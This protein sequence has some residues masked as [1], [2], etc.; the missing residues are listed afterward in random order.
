MSKTKK[1]LSLCY[2]FI[3]SNGIEIDID[4]VKGSI[5]DKLNNNQMITASDLGLVDIDFYIAK[6]DRESDYDMVVNKLGEPIDDLI[7]LILSSSVKYSKKIE[8]LLNKR[9]EDDSNIK[10]LMIG[11][12]QT[13]GKYTI[14]IK[15][16]IQALYD[17][18]KVPQSK[19]K[20]EKVSSGI[21]SASLYDIVSIYNDLGDEL[22]KKNVRLRVEKDSIGVSKE[23][24]DTLKK[25]PD[26]FWFL[27]NGITIVTNSTVDMSNNTSI[28]LRMDEKN[29][30]SVVNGAQTVSAAHDYFFCNDEEKNQ[31]ENAKKARVLLRVVSVEEIK[32]KND[33][34]DDCDFKD[35]MSERISKSLNRQKPIEPEDLAYY[36]SFV[37]GVN[38]IYSDVC[39]SDSDDQDNRFFRIIRRGENESESVNNFEHSLT[40]I[41]RAIRASGYSKDNNRLYQPWR[42]INT[43]NAAILKMTGNKLK[44]DDLFKDELIDNIDKFLSE[45]QY[46][47]LAVY[48]YKYYAKEKNYIDV[49]DYKN[50]DKIEILKESG[51]WYFVSFFFEYLLENKSNK[52]LQASCID[53]FDDFIDKNLFDDL[54]RFFFSVMDDNKS[55]FKLRD[56][57]QATTYND[58]K[59]HII[60]HDKE[61]KIYKAKVQK[62]YISYENG[63]KFNY[64]GYEAKIIVEENKLVLKAGSEIEINIDNSCS[65]KVKEI[66]KNNEMY[67][68][69]NGKTK[70]DIEFGDLSTAAKFVEARRIV[71]GYKNWIKE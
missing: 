58:I 52:K 6:I 34:Y 64:L 61:L 46:V 65:Q 56:L 15:S 42:A 7:M 17:S 69:K 11:N 49:S 43:Y 29:S 14:S 26:Q 27:N 24:K 10:V 30:F 18:I 57:R 28:C 19:T 45:Y 22:F 33:S 59:S 53:D 48:I 9:K 25:N 5:Y 63:D 54:I 8:I 37:K 16:R 23:I 55:G 35:S 21:Y 2:E 44:Q 32:E 1:I 20:S 39:S 31:I 67:I 50:K 41:A 70:A 40:L 12:S 36:S 60:N 13:S 66:R 62:L 3:E 71:K 51:A 38:A 47:N 68:D 4:D